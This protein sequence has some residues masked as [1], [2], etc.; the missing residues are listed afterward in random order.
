MQAIATRLELGAGYERLFL[1]RVSPQPVARGPCSRA[2]SFPF[3]RGELESLV[4]A[5]D[6]ATLDEAASETFAA[7]WAED[8]WVY[9]ALHSTSGLAG[10][11]RPLARGRWSALEKRGADTA[12]RF[13]QRLLS[14]TCTNL[15]AFEKIGENLRAARL[16][17]TGEELGT[18]E[19]LSLEQITPALPPL[20][21][22]GSIQLVDLVSEATREALENPLRLLRED[23]THPRPKV[24]G[25]VHFAKGQKMLVCNELVRRGIC[26]W[27]ETSQ[28]VSV[29]GVQILNGLF[30]VRKPSSLEDGRPILRV[31]MNLKPTNSV[32]SQIRGAVDGL[33]AITAWQAALLE[34]EEGFHYYQSD[35]SSAFYLFELP[36]DWRPL[37]AFSVHCSGRE[38]GKADDSSYTLACRVLP[39]GM[40]SSVS[41]MQEVSETILWREG[42]SQESQVR[43]G[44]PVPRSLVVAAKQS[45]NEDRCFWQVYLDNFMGGDKREL[46]SSSSVGDKVHQVCDQTWKKHGILSSDKKKVSDSQETEELGALLQGR[47]GF[48]GAS[49][50]RFCKLIQSTLWLLMQRPVKTRMVQVV[51]GR[52]IHALQFRRPGMSFL[53]KTWSFINSAAPRDL[54]ALQMKREMFLIMG[55]VPLLHTYFGAEVDN[56][57]WCS[58]ASER[59]GAV[60][61][62]SELTPE[63]VDFV[64]S[65][66]INGKHLGTAPILVIGLFS[67]IGGTYRVYDLLDVLPR[68]MIG[69]DIHA[70][71]N[72]VVSRR[73][74][75]VQLLRDI[76][77]IGRDEVRSWARDFHTVDEIHLWG[78]FP[79]RDLSS[80]R[81]NRQNLR[82]EQ[83]GLF[84]EFLRIWQL[85]SEEFSNRVT[86]KVAAE[87]VASMDESAAAEI[88]SWMGCSPY[89]LD[90]VG[91]V[92]LRRPRLCWTTETIEGCLQGV[93]VSSDRRWKKVEAVSP[94]PLVEQWITNGFSW[95]GENDA[96]AFPTCM[97]AVWKESPPPQPAGLHRAD[98]DC[99]H[100]WALCGYTYHLTNFGQSSCFGKGTSG[101]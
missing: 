60:G 55:A 78:G 2:A 46:G 85:L 27:I 96:G 82:G 21:H 75:A 61:F 32:M 25:A 1:T 81:S 50:Q 88:S 71:A 80:A 30:G 69:V 89:H 41:L 38:L 20:G 98:K 12:R 22:G 48:V 53:D 97:R 70:P 44:R 77:K 64:L 47:L 40:H 86:I 3:R 15:T 9:L 84:F 7:R 17:Y 28:V 52:W 45:L 11:C 95:P 62:S 94:Y 65:S 5:L 83:S 57:V 99:R 36:R 91:A 90:S 73:W 39:M 67:G 92:P 8:A 72:R 29:N 76:T 35:I 54:P 58:D 43:R 87:N 59:A 49:P 74:P 101:A 63:G 24:P 79:C 33:P 26:V 100:R 51:A 68:G 23:F 14:C 42:L 10:R 66:Q 34:G 37:L 16:D 56:K 18:C 31:I 93:S 13:V 4:E 19:P 6:R